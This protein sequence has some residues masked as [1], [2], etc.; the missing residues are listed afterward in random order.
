MQKQRKK[1]LDFSVSLKVTFWGKSRKVKE[2]KKTIFFFSFCKI[3]NWI[4]TFVFVPNNY[5]L[6]FLILGKKGNFC[7]DDTAIFFRLFFVDQFQTCIVNK[8]SYLVRERKMVQLRKTSHS[9][10]LSLKGFRQSRV[11][12]VKMYPNLTPVFMN[13]NFVSQVILRSILVN[14]TV[15]IN[16]QVSLESL[17][18]GK[19]YGI[20]NSL[21]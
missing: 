16:A 4:K 8:R 5:Y 9:W 13:K 12:K 17:N 18:Y 15:E 11:K 21:F 6:N 2:K 7:S 19:K 20:E 10:N 3:S 1:T 14:H